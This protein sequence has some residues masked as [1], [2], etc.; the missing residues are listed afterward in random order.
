MRFRALQAFTGRL[1]LVDQPADLALEIPLTGTDTQ[2]AIRSGV[3]NG[4]AAEV[5][6]LLSEYTRQF[7]TLAVILAGGDAPFF[8]TRLKRPI[9]VVPELVLLGL[10]RILV[11]HVST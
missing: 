10:H 9:F 8:R 5:R 6:E 1:P 4:A 7:P 11:H 2:A 3:L